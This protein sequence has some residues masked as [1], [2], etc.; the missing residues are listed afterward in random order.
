M[1]AVAAH[2]VTGHGWDNIRLIAAPVA[3]APID[4]M[5][6]AAL[7][8]AVHDIMQ[9]R[10]PLD[11]IVA[12]L[13]RLTDRRDRRQTAAVSPGRHHRQARDQPAP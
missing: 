3:T 9:S 11:N 7:F 10:A 8:C 1:L 4:G 13:G 12:H 5:A 6:D 2:R